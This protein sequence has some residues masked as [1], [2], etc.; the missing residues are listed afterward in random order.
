MSG[1][2]D[3]CRDYQH[4]IHSCLNLLSP[5]GTL[6]FSTNARGFKF[7][8]GLFLSTTSVSDIQTKTIDEDFIGK[9]NRFC[10]EFVKH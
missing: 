5:G 3:I 8:A 10:F 9:R 6:L 4:I 7:D 1:T 2:L